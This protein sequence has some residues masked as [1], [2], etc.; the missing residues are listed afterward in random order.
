MRISAVLFDHDGTLVDSEPTHF[1]IWQKVLAPY[2]VALSEK[3]YKDYY[4]GV[5][6]AANAVDMV[7]RFAINEVPATLAD[8]KNSATR[9]FLSRSAFSLMP[10]VKEVLSLLRSDGLRL[11]VV[12]G[13]GRNG[14]EATLRA[15]SLHDFF[16]TVVSGDDV[17]QSKPAPDCY[18]LAI[19]RL[20]L[21]PSECIAIED[22]EHGVNAATSAGIT[23]LAVPTAMSEHHSFAKA[24][25]VLSELSASVPWVRSH[26]ASCQ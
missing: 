13:A 7:S 3:Q 1:Q 9:T 17:R 6:T 25:A 20:G 19:E 2:G 26:H 14:V 5:P 8:A 18:L 11:A 12:T 16:E 21:S 4:A 10:G 23:C 24:A 22:T 15:H